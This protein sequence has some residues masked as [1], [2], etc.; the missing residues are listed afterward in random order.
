MRIRVALFPVDHAHG[1]VLLFTGRTEYIEKYGPLARDLAG[2][3]F[4]MATCDWRGQGLS[5][6]ALDE[7]RT[8]HVMRFSDYQIDA[9]ALLK[10]AQD[11]GLPEPY[12]LIGHSMG[13]CIGLRSLVAGYPVSA[14]AFSAPMWGIGMA[15][16]LRPFAWTLSFLSRF[17]NRSHVFA[18]GTTG[19]PYPEAAP[20]EDNQLTTDAEQ[21]AW[22]KNQTEMHPELAL[23]GP[24]LNW[25]YEGMLETRALARLPS[26]D[27]PCL[28][29]L[30]GNERIVDTDRIHERMQIWP[31]GALEI[32]PGGEHEVLME[33]PPLRERAIERITGFFD[34]HL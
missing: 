30:G 23:G 17:V 2:R 6:R 10:A 32:V 18:P 19:T 24:S 21:Y 16:Y 22:M 27:V 8:G 14:V 4:A 33:R 1:T 28:T 12:F 3:G 5:D 26:P 25:L 11:A 31:D 7:K 9:D 15:G 13:G 29:L 20:F 34:T